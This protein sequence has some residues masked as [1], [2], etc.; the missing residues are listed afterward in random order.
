MFAPRGG[1]L[2]GQ[3]PNA[4]AAIKIPLHPASRRYDKNRNGTG[5]ANQVKPG[6]LAG[7]NHLRIVITAAGTHPELFP[8]Q[9]IFS[10]GHRQRH[11]FAVLST[12]QSRS[13][14]LPPRT[15]RI[16]SKLAD[17]GISRDDF[18]GIARLVAHVGRQILRPAEVPNIM[19]GLNPARINSSRTPAVKTSVHPL[20]TLAQVCRLKGFY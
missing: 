1:Q 3:D 2:P 4:D 9:T 12:S 14:R 20:R 6:S 15:K 5:G 17:S 11:L 10:V 13:I 8:G 19:S 16:G 7:A 18:A